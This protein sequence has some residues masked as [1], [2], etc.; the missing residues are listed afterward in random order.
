[1][2]LCFGTYEHLANLSFSLAASKTG[3]YFW[4]DL[5]CAGSDG[6][7]RFE[8]ESSEKPSS[9]VSTPFYCVAAKKATS[10]ILDIIY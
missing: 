3:S 7:D 1:M 9:Q 5:V 2:V 4:S 10:S 8:C 6:K